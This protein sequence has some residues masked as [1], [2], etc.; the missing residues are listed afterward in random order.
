MSNTL[1]PSL[2]LSHRPTLSLMW[3]GLCQNC[4]WILVKGNERE[5]REGDKV[6]RAEEHLQ[7]KCNSMKAPK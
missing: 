2:S 6:V 5:A 7:H 1:S 3:C 4:E